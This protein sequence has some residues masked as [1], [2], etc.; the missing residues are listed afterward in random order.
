MVSLTAQK[1]GSKIGFEWGIM[2]WNFFFGPEN[3]KIVDCGLEH[4]HVLCLDLVALQ[5]TS[6]VFYYRELFLAC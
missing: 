6:N 2:T 1:E 3:M 5:L 4:I